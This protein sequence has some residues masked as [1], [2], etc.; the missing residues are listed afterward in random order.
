MSV[1]HSF[2]R[3]L[4]RAAIGLALSSAALLQAGCAPLLGIPGQPGLESAR[5]VEAAAPAGEDEKKYHEVSVMFGTDRNQVGGSDSAHRF[6][7]SRGLN[8][9]R[10]GYATVSIPFNHEPG[11]LE[12]YHWYRLEFSPDPQRDIVLLGTDTLSRQAWVS[13]MRS[14][15]NASPT[16]SQLIYIHGFNV[17]FQ[18][19]ARRAAQLAWDLG[20]KGVPA[21]FS[22]ASAAETFEYTTDEATVDWSAPH[23]EEFLENA[24]SAA[25]ARNVYIIAH[26]MG[27]RV[28]SRALQQMA[29]N[30]PALKGRIKDI[31][32]AAPDID[33][34]VFREQIVP[35]L[36]K[37]TSVTL[38]ASSNDKAILASY[39]IH[40]YE[41][42][43]SGPPHLVVEPPMETIDASA[44]DTD[45]LSLGHSYYGDKPLLIDDL[46]ELIDGKKAAERAPRIVPAERSGG[47]Y[48]T[49]AN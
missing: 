16:R 30:A 33:A 2:R 28:L 40:T 27:A 47:V 7:T 15:L 36:A 8:Q 42:A 11:E 21:F 12:T 31:I 32:F 20:F 6:G 38:Y 49:F 29:L 39:K 5:P 23:L 44:V 25:D 13:E 17:S 48:F 18:D 22:W 3:V 34:D 35:R 46:K 43:G 4:R 26:S 9:V 19:A 45:F 41:R 24:I 37:D 14:R 1:V 10:Y